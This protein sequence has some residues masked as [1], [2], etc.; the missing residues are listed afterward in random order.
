MYPSDPQTKTNEIDHRFLLIGT[1]GRLMSS[2][3]PYSDPT[4]AN[5]QPYSIINFFILLVF[6]LPAIP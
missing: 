4:V 1:I 5:I 3:S 2:P 6:H